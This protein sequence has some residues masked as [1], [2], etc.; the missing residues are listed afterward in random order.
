MALIRPLAPKGWQRLDYIHA[1]ARRRSSTT[2]PA[3][4]SWTWFYDPEGGR[5]AHPAGMTLTGQAVS[6]ELRRGDVQ[7]GLQGDAHPGHRLPLQ[8]RHL[9]RGPDDHPRLVAGPSGPRAD[10]DH[11]EHQR[12]TARAPGRRRRAAVRRPRP[13]TRS[14]PRS[15]RCSA[16]G[17]LITP[18][19][20]RGDAPHLA[21][22]RAEARLADAGRRA[23]QVPLR[24]RRAGPPPRGLSR[25]PR[26]TL[27]GRV[28]FVDT[29]ENLAAT[30]PTSP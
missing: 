10:P 3:R 6:P 29:D 15:S 20:V 16:R 25:R 28:F 30:A 24:P 7:A 22:R 19:E 12:R 17:K 18:D 1:P 2:A 26:K 27:E 13:T 11:H 9:R 4:W 21:R 14:T 23:R 8:L 5:F